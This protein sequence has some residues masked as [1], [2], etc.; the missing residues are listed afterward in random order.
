MY[1][2]Y[3]DVV[4]EKKVK[5]AQIKGQTIKHEITVNNYLADE[6]HKIA[7]LEVENIKNKH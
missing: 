6:E 1:Q 2:S 4:N 7:K 5:E 3:V